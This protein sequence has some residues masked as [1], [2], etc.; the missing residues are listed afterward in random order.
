MVLFITMRSCWNNLSQPH[1]I[2]AG[3]LP[4]SFHKN[5]V[6]EKLTVWY[7]NSTREETLR[8]DVPSPATGATRQPHL[9]MRC[10]LCPLGRARWISAAATSLL[11]L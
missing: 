8:R 4:Q 7:A 10:Y 2:K 6:D 11:G 5:H 9:P 3:F 1:L